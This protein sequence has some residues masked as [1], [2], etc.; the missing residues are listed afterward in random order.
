ML[1]LI[2]RILDRSTVAPML[3]LVLLAWFVLVIGIGL[4]KQ[5]NAYSERSTS[6]CF[7]IDDRT[8]CP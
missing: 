1:N 4:I 6:E 2:D 5:A 3:L 8:Y 7:V